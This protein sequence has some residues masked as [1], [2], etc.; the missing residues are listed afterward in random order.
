MAR[1]A[2]D[3]KVLTAPIEVKQTGDGVGFFSAA[4]T[5]FGI[6]DHDGDIVEASAIE[7]GITLPVMWAHRHM[8]MPVA[9]GTVRKTERQGLIEGPFIDSQMGRDAH[10][11]LLATKEVQEMSWA[12]EVT[13]AHEGSRDGATVRIITGTKPIEASFVLRGSNPET[14]I[15]AIKC[16]ACEAEPCACT[17]QAIAAHGTAVRD[18]PW[19]GPRAEAM[20]SS[21]ATSA[22]LRNMYAWRDPDG[23]PATK[24]AYKFIHHHWEG[25]PGPANVRACITGIAV[26]N[27]ARGGTTIPAGDRRG[28][29]AH[30][31]RHLR[32]ADMEP[33]ELRAAPKAFSKHITQA[34]YEVAS[35]ALRVHDRVEARSADGRALS[36]RDHGLVAALAETARDLLIELE[37]VL[38]RKNGQPADLEI[39]RRA[40]HA[41]LRS[42]VCQVL[43]VPVP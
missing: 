19:N 27:G 15:L 43:G 30:L 7:D 2:L 13:E 35:A 14:G 32:D 16:E 31:A 26:L 33:P 29:H 4:F 9:I 6:V 22:Q 25:G 3:R 18:A 11:T 21:E 28:V 17:K 20:I 24:A 42:E 37:P 38:R 36:E 1:G 10:A 12:F 40:Y 39:A 8:D 41:V 34:I 23:D 5:T